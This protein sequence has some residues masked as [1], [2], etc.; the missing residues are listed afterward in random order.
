MP[1][2]KVP[3]FI[4]RVNGEPLAELVDKPVE[5]V[6]PLMETMKKT[7]TVSAIEQLLKK[8]TSVSPTGAEAVA[9]A[10]HFDVI[11]T[12]FLAVARAQEIAVE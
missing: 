7:R 2:K 11:N 12:W 4:D 1:P 3:L 10:Q 6:A 8:H 5:A 9:I